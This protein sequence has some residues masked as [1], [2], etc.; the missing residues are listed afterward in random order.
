MLLFHITQPSDFNEI[1]RGSSLLLSVMI[2]PNTCNYGTTPVIVN[3]TMTDWN[4]ELN[5]SEYMHMH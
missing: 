2:P 1:S 3:I 4:L 5:G